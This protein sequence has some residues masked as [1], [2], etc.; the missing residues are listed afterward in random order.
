MKLIVVLLIT[1]SSFAGLRKIEK[2]A[3]T[4]YK[5]DNEITKTSEGNNIISRKQLYGLYLNGM[6]INFDERNVSFKL[7][8]AVIMG[9]NADLINVTIDE[10]HPKFEEFTNLLQKDLYLFSSICV[11][12]N[13]NVVEYTINN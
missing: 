6:K 10:A 11:D 8:Q 3:C 12:S 7:K 4:E 2:Q 9:F 13:K 5:V 1:F